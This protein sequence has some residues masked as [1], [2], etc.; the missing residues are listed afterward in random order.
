[1]VNL[2]SPLVHKRYDTSGMFNHIKNFPAQ[3]H[4][5]WE[6][7]MNYNLP[8][9]FSRA[10]KVI[11]LGMGGSAIGGE[12]VGDLLKSENNIPVWI[13][14]DFELPCFVDEKTLVITVI[15]SGNTEE[16]LSAFS[17][18]M[19]IP[20]MKLVLTGGGQLAEL[21][22]KEN[23]F[24][25][26][27]KYES[28]PRAAFPYMFAS[29]LGMFNKLGFSYEKTMDMRHTITFLN[30][31]IDELD[32]TIPLAANR[33]K[34]LAYQLFHKIIVIYGAGVLSGAARRWKTQF[35]ENS[36]NWA[37]FEILPELLHNAVNG[38]SS[39]ALAKKSEFPILLRTPSLHPRVKIQYDAVIKV[40]EENG[41][42]FKV[43]DGN[44]ETALQQV[45]GIIL[46]GD[47][48]SYYLAILNRVDPT[49]VPVI[50]FIKQYMANNRG[51]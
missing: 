44:G 26:T 30:R 17:Q 7:V 29:L 16:T 5:A 51:E 18:L 46:L 4:S 13:Q 45:L 38:Y 41:V 31:M 42:S 8:S 47:F 20:A 28:P 40:L 43:I 10:N 2:D 6:E 24:L 36:K 15:F 1:M 27:I 32:V 37:F 19:K 25:S 12:I 11:I 39:P 9:D 35:N 48:T 23:I 50:T 14:R 49:P 3:C 34:Q 21:A 22:K 33:A